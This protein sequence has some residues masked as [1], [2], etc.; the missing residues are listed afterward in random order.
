MT[1]LVNRERR[2][3]YSS[4]ESAADPESPAL[5][6]YIDASMRLLNLIDTP[7]TQATLAN[8]SSVAPSTSESDVSDDTKMLN[9]TLNRMLPLRSGVSTLLSNAE[10]HTAA[11]AQTSQTFRKIGAGACGAIFAQDGKPVV[12]KLAKSDDPSEM[13]NDYGMHLRVSKA[14]ERYIID[15]VRVP[16]C[17]FFVPP[18]NQGFFEH[19]PGL[20]EVARNICNF[21]TH[22]LVT[23]RIHPLPSKTR[24]LLIDKYCAPRI[25]EKARTDAANKDCL[26]R[27]YLGSMRGKTGAMFFSLRNFKL[28]LNQVLELQLDVEALAHRMGIVLAVMHWAAR[29]DARDVEFLLGSLKKRPVVDFDKIEPYSYTRPPSGRV[30]DFY[31]RT[32]ELFVLDF[33]QAR[34]ITLDDKGVALAVEAWQLNDPYYP[35][36]PCRCETPIQHTIWKAFATCYLRVSHT[37]L[38]EEVGEENASDLP[39]K[40][41]L[42]VS[43]VE[44]K[45][46]ESRMGEG[47]QGENYVED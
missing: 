37:I 27:V 18:T 24:N 35:R 28:H 44:K 23:E 17:Y 20:A 29:T 14:F 33:N 1:S 38:S 30:K 26:V 8:N 36:P 19:C 11:Q 39:L 7:T 25:R 32:T 10:W 40:F 15:Q 21:P 3:L 16:G 6:Q 22:V 47:V 34:P 45:K 4:S 2:R 42:G 13:W 43:D 12:L 31:C 46:M 41:L 9:Q 5:E